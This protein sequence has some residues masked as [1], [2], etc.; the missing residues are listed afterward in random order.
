[1]LLE[2]AVDV[3]AGAAELEHLGYFALTRWDEQDVFRA[4]VAMYDADR[5]RANQ[6]AGN[7]GDD[8]V[9]GAGVEPTLTLD[10]RPKTLALL[11]LH[12]QKRDTVPFT[13]IE[14]VEYVLAADLRNRFHS[15]TVTTG[16][17]GYVARV[18]ICQAHGTEAP[19][20]LVVC[21]PD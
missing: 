8:F 4:E 19:G 20:S 14:A 21:E 2:A 11:V 10:S 12:D 17:F 5:V 13:A 15:V 18:S 9:S 16:E 3:G 1:M 7:L 6:G